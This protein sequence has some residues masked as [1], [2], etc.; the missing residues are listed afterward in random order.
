M[1]NPNEDDDLDTKS[2][3]SHGLTTLSINETSSIHTS[4]F[5][6]ATTDHEDMKSLGPDSL[7]NT[8]KV[9]HQ[10]KARRLEDDLITDSESVSMSRT[11]TNMRKV[12]ERDLDTSQTLTSFHDH[13]EDATEGDATPRAFRKS[14]AD[15]PDLPSESTL[16]PVST[17]RSESIR[18]K[19]D[20]LQTD[21]EHSLHTDTVSGAGT[22][23]RRRHRTIDDAVSIA[24][25]ITEGLG[26]D[27]L[28]HDTISIHSSATLPGQ[29]LI[30]DDS[31]LKSATSEADLTSQAT[32]QPGDDH[33]FSDATPTQHR[34]SI[35]DTM[36]IGNSDS[37]SL[38]ATSMADESK[39]MSQSDTISHNSSTL[40]APASVSM[41][42]EA[43]NVSSV[44]KTESASLA[45]SMTPK[46]LRQDDETIAD[47]VSSIDGQSLKNVD[48]LSVS[49][50]SLKSQGSIRSHASHASHLSKT[51][52]ASKKSG[53]STTT[54]RSEAKTLSSVGA[55]IGDS[56]ADSKM[57]KG[58]DTISVT[59]DTLHSSALGAPDSASISGSQMTG[60]EV[61][62]GKG[63]SDAMSYQGAL[64]RAPSMMS[65]TS[66]GQMSSVS[67]Q[68]RSREKQSNLYSQYG[69]SDTA[70]LHSSSSKQTTSTMASMKVS[71]IQSIYNSVYQGISDYT[72]IFTAEL[73]VLQTQL[74]HDSTPDEAKHE[75]EEQLKSTE[76]ILTKLNYQQGQATEI[77][78]Q[79]KIQEKYLEGRELKKGQS[80]VS[81]QM[82]QL[83]KELESYLG[84]F[85]IKM[86]GLLGFAR[87]KAGDNYEVS[88]KYGGQRWKLKG[89]VK[90]SF[91]QIWDSTEFV[92]KPKIGDIMAIKV[93]EARSVIRKQRVVGNV[94]CE[95][96]DL[97][98]AELQELAIDLNSIG[99]LKISLNICWTPFD[100]ED[101]TSPP[102]EMIMA[103][104]QASSDMQS[105]M[106]SSAQSVSGMT[107]DNTSV[108]RSSAYG[109]TETDG[110]SIGK[111]SMKSGATLT[112]SVSA[113]SALNSHSYRS[114]GR[115]SSRHHDM[116]DTSTI[117]MTETVT[118]G[119]IMGDRDTLSTK[120]KVE[121]YDDRY[122]EEKM[123]E[124]L[125][126]MDI[127]EEIQNSMDPKK[128]EV[129]LGDEMVDPEDIEAN[130][131]K[132]IKLGQRL[133]DSIVSLN[134]CLDDY[135]G[136]YRELRPLEEH[137]Q[138]LTIIV[139]RGGREAPLPLSIEEQSA[140]NA[141][142]FLDGDDNRTIIEDDLM[143]QSYKSCRSEL[144]EEDD[145]P[146]TTGNPVYDESLLPHI[147]AAELLL[148]SLGAYGP[149]R[150]KEIIAL[151]KLIKHGFII[152]RLLELCRR[153]KNLEIR[154][155]PECKDKFS[156]INIWT[157]AC[158]G[159][160]R[161]AVTGK[162][163]RMELKATHG[164]EV[165]QKH[166]D[167]SELVF[168]ELVRRVL[169]R[170]D[171]TDVDPHVITLH[172]WLTFYHDLAD[173]ERVEFA[174]YVNRV[175]L[176]LFITGMLESKVDRLV[177]S[178]IKRLQGL[179][180]LRS[181]NI[182][183]L[184][185]L[186]LDSNKEV[187]NASAAH[188]AH[189]GTDSSF[190]EKALCALLEF[191][192]DDDK[193]VRWAAALALGFVGC[194]EATKHIQYVF[195][196]DIEP[197]VREACKN[198]LMSFGKPGKVA[199]EEA[200]CTLLAQTSSHTSTIVNKSK[201][202]TAL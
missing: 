118:E 151:D 18:R 52:H 100:P 41:N 20:D 162:I 192:E 116:T 131:G 16:T 119:S 35:A 159:Q 136:C 173:E 34:K 54:E 56:I 31:R 55:S 170:P 90:S 155:L 153:K 32:L 189:I 9:K 191:L 147:Q 174:K 172:Q 95:T 23:N 142:E 76:R 33:T 198:V 181:T 128:Q 92:F 49:G 164:T 108:S 111:S 63:S 78:E 123:K 79:Y 36:S 180:A 178:A 115:S 91:E 157:S 185:V 39:L 101:P 46:S 120:Y 193:N 150:V 179:L 110:L 156:A 184:A 127:L 167:V 176:E 75:L 152:G 84:R 169:G 43:F 114:R 12:K 106:M 190:R 13:D 3:T 146:P 143:S 197:E 195:M 105:D 48:A 94:T 186:L 135:R 65:V 89:Q 188:L 67:Q 50:I 66:S 102:I 196:A 126:N 175:A 140:L 199:L 77:Y 45:G 59:T 53:I 22:G 107:G 103:R 132:D 68:R 201:M 29:S 117:D 194:R 137:V 133:Y 8:P 182:R 42:S 44:G 47:N 2:V 61:R 122:K 73:N 104:L 81:P 60:H 160:Q 72:S 1:S 37:I 161:L 139:K 85:H 141:F 83:E 11:P 93:S 38:S 88:I 171:I 177:L 17:R 21:V 26:E 70:S 4:D 40:H 202:G 57:T 134:L 5:L 125:K 74:L 80:E 112:N 7:V 24:G 99:S 19:V 200:C 69:Q 109:K 129:F 98:S 165:K 168:P 97:F 145:V 27:D 130:N 51:S 144:F 183:A 138:N 25:T 166:S 149:C 187:R 58:L 87:L 86:K 15:D 148:P 64:S 158:D 82:Q 28:K 121:T 71:R 113:S 14:Q 30:S 96:R 62:R 6:S 154:S 124:D 10:L 163:F